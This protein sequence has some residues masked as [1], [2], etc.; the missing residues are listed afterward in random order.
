MKKGLLSIL[1]SALLVVGCQN[2]DDQFTNLESQIN[3]LASTVA[4]LT[5]VQSDLAGLAAQVNSL[6]GAIDSAVDTALANGLADIDAAIETLNAAAESA[7]NNSDITAIAEDVDQVQSD[8]AE[9]LA[10]S[11]VFQGNV[12]VSTPAMLDAYHAMGDGLA[13]I[14]GYVDI[15]V[16]A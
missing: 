9:L 16:T 5:Q 10:Q 1:A 14:N 12:V 13:I 15:D 11:S 3:A 7:A 8:L 2:Y 4:G 6:S